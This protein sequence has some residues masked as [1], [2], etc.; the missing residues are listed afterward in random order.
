MIRFEACR[1]PCGSGKPPEVTFAVRDRNFGSTSASSRLL[2]CSECSSLFPEIVPTRE[3]IVDAYQN[4]YTLRRGAPLWRKAW[5]FVLDATRRPYSRRT[6]FKPEMVLDFGCGSGDYLLNMRQVFPSASLTGTDIT[7]PSLEPDA[8]VGWI[9]IDEVGRRGEQYDLVTLSHVIE[10]VPDAAST[11]RLATSLLKS[12]GR[13][14]IAAPNS[15]SFLFRALGEYARDVDFPRHRFIPSA[16]LLCR[17]FEHCGL[18]VS[19]CQP[20][21]INAMLTCVSG[22]RN[23]L[24][25]PRLSLFTKFYLMSRAVLALGRY[26]LASSHR[27]LAQ[28]PELVFIA[29]RVPR[30]T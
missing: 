30:T 20:P 4:Y 29:R 24:A 23:V 19:R 6:M 9:S 25:E 12:D 16:S 27:R 26:L 2:K 7:E 11:A 8:G 17:L 28:A 14:W 22:M 13:L 1:C 21:R 18:V 3:T 10:H 5:R 15:S